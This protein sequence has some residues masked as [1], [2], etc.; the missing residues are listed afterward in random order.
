MSAE[1]FIQNCYKISELITRSYSTSFSK[2]TLLLEKEKREAVYA[3]YGFVRLADEIVDSLHDYNKKLLLD[4][5]D[6]QL[7]Y[8]LENGISEN[9]IITAF[10][11]TVKKY[12]IDKNHIN[13]F[14]ESMHTDITKNSYSSLEE[15]KRYIY[16]SAEVVGLMCLR[17]FCYGDPALYERLE[18]SARKLG[19]A[20]QKVNFLRDL[21]SDSNILHRVYFPQ[22]FE[23][24]LDR[25]NK[26]G[27]E[28]DIE[29]DFQEALTGIKQLPGRSKLAVALSYHYFVAL[30]Y[31]IKKT[32]PDELIEERLRT[33]NFTKFFILAKVMLMYKTN[34]I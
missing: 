16:G 13:A 17:V 2:A 9:A 33:G 6:K 8:A 21:G 20:F 24:E 23:T 5:L 29:E 27:I 15:L 25:Y 10:A 1:L 22:L 28:Q 31:K 19:S 14:M 26:S 3:I 34:R 18:H 30:L 11:H 12:N 4:N 7:D 32:A